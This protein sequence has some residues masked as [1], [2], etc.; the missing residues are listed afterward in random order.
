MFVSL[1]FF[2]HGLFLSLGIYVYLS[3]LM[4]VFISL[5]RLLS[6]GIHVDLFRYFVSSFFLSSVM[7]LF[8]YVCMYVGLFIG[9]YF[10]L[11]DVL[12]YCI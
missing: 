11:S 12:S 8:L 3:L 10:F 6:F 5:A 7:S 1:S 4:Y 2:F 9:L